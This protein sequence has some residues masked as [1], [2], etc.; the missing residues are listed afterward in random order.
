MVD[1]YDTLIIGG[2]PGGYVA[3]IRV[4]SV[5]SWGLNNEFAIALTVGLR[6]PKWSADGVEIF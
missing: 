3:A 1:P 5:P 2:G 6:S 4:P